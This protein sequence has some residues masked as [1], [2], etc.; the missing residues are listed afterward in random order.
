MSIESIEGSE[1]IPFEA[2]WLDTTLELKTPTMTTAEKVGC[3]ACALISY[4]YPII[5]F[6]CLAGWGF[7]R[8]ANRIARSKMLPIAYE[9]LNE[10]QLHA[11]KDFENFFNSQTTFELHPQT[12]ITPDGARLSAMWVKDTR[13]D[14]HTPTMIY[15]NCNFQVYQEFHTRLITESINS[16]TPCHFVLFNY[17]GVDDSTGTL[18]S[19][20]DLVIDGSSIVQWVRS[21]IKTPPDRIHFCGL[22]LGGAIALMTQALDPELTG[23]NINYN[24]FSSSTKILSALYGDGLAGRLANYIFEWQGY[25]ADPAA[26]FGK[27]RGEK[28]ILV[29]PDDMVIPHEASLQN[30]VHHDNV[31][32]LKPMAE[33]MDLSKEL[34][35]HAA[36]IEWHEGNVMD[37]LWKFISAP[38]GA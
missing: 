21:Q 35:H 27:I 36:P 33:Y 13:A 37:K 16:G 9:P 8:L 29:N 11:K 10:R 26:A 38:V 2:V 25:S 12:V 24:S 1:E 31:L 19:G 23:R 5:A 30:E 20:N 34:G 6:A 15:F 17:R 22:S 4:V 18:Q 3:V 32:E 14:E 7:S 28:L